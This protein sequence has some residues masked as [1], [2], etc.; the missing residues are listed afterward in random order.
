[1]EANKSENKLAYIDLTEQGQ[2]VNGQFFGNK[3]VV[4]Y[5]YKITPKA[6]V[7]KQLLHPTI[8]EKL[9]KLRKDVGI[10]D[11][12]ENQEETKKGGVET[13]HNQDATYDVDAPAK[14]TVISENCN[15]EILLLER[16]AIQYVPDKIKGLLL[17][18]LNSEIDFDELDME[19]HFTNYRIWNQYKINAFQSEMAHLHSIKKVK[20]I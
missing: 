11:E 9:E 20:G 6:D 14:L 10:E 7:K 8:Q 5:A 18:G 15:T 2:Y 3:T 13:L 4:N 19:T 17:S 12:E 1:M 16:E